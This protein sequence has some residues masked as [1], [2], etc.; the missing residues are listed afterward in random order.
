LL[1]ALSMFAAVPVMFAQGSAGTVRGDIK[2]PNGAVVPNATVT[3]VDARGGER[4]ATTTSSGSYTF[5]S[6][7]PGQYTI[8]VEGPGFKTSEQQF[9]LAPNETRGLDVALEIGT[10]TETV[11]VTDQ[12]SAIKTETGERSDTITATQI[13]NQ[14]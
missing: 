3:L 7:D 11:T 8:R 4:K 2:D 5:T 14:P 1:A 12:G 6:V 13:E 9:S 10:A